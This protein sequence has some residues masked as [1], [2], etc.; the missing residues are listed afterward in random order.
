MTSL[1][2]SERLGSHLK[3]AEQALN[4][5]KQ[6]ALKPS[7]LT[8]PQYAALLHLDD[9]PGMSAAALARKCAVT[10]PTMNTVLK[11]LQERG[12]IER[13]PHE[14]HR[15][16]LET[17]ITPEGAAVLESADARAVR[18]ERGLAAEFTDAERQTLIDL[19]GRCVGFLEAARSAPGG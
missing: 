17:R 16:I 4:G 19:L 8:V 11:N 13:T 5:A 3:R 10:P 18:V 12:L 6:A 14:W 7:G 15:N 2:A 1:P 9:N